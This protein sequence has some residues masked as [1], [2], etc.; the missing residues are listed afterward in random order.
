[1]QL[2]HGQPSS[3]GHAEEIAPSLAPYPIL[4][5]VRYF[6]ET[7][8]PLPAPS[9]TRPV[10]ETPNYLDENSPPPVRTPRAETAPVAV[11]EPKHEA[12][13]DRVASP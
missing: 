4:M 12:V 6:A 13:L 2:Y 7:D 5:R 3:A 10:L 11:E 1:M 8:E 9:V